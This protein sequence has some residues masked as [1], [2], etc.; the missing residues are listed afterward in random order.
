MM[1]CRFHRSWGSRWPKACCSFDHL[2]APS[3][4]LAKE[5]RVERSTREQL[6]RRRPMLPTAVRG[7]NRCNYR[8]WLRRWES[9]TRSKLTI[10]PSRQ[11][12][13]TRPSASS[14]D[15]RTRLLRRRLYDREGLSAPGAAALSGNYRR[16][17]TKSGWLQQG[18]WAVP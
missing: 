16:L 13:P 10:D 18:T 4:R 1:V 15:R 12:G 2:A 17:A 5:N 7:R 11:S 14:T 9:L 3:E 6:N 8:C